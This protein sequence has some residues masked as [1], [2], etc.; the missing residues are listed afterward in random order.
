MTAAEHERSG[1]IEAVEG[2][3][4]RARRELP[5]DRQGDQE[6]EEDRQRC[7]ADPPGDP[8]PLARCR[9]AHALGEEPP[10]HQ[11]GDDDDG[12][13]RQGHRDGEGRDGR[14]NGEAGS[15]AIRRQRPR[16][17]PHRG[18]HHGD[19][20]QLEAVEPA[21]VRHPG[22]LQREREDHEG[23]GRWK[24]EAEPGGETSRQARASDSHRDPDL[25]TGRPGKELA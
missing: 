4:R 3:E 15:L 20:R 6:G 18:G 10:A 25:A 17:A 8:H 24:R 13:L 9:A 7:G 11:S 19:R 22:S 21:G 1:S 23:D 12:H 14:G 16:H 2:G 5:G